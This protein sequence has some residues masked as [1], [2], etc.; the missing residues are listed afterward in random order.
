MSGKIL[1]AIV[2][3]LEGDLDFD[4][5]FGFAPGGFRYVGT[6]VLVLTLS[7]D[8]GVGVGGSFGS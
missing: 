8:E 4:A 5:D 1:S 2:V 6:G 3:G 7:V